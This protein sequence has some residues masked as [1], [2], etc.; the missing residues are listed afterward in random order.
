MSDT[1]KY[2][3][4]ELAEVLNV[5]RTTVTDWLVRY[6][7]Y[8]DY[9]I[10]GKRKVY[11]DMSVGVLKEISELRN[12]GLSSY[13]IEEELS[14]RHP[15]HGE[16]AD[17]NQ[18]MEEGLEPEESDSTSLVL[19]K[20]M[21]EMGETIKNTLIEVNRRM[22]ELEKM[23][24]ANASKANIWFAVVVILMFALISV[25]AFFYLKI[26][27]SYTANQT[28][29]LENRAYLTELKKAQEQMDE[30][31]NVIQK[32]ETEILK[33]ESGLEKQAK[34]MKDSEAARTAEMTEQK[35][36]W[37]EEKLKLLKDLDNAKQDKEK[38][39]QVQEA[40]KKQE[41][42]QNEQIKKIEEKPALPVEIKEEPK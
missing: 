27:T 34:E 25:G 28:L 17:R 42:A 22:E 15:V 29:L 13:D 19:R 30:N 2:T 6:S 21:T 12:K 5:P 9:K 40:V 18:P 24:E 31:R 11:T 20:S 14:K 23:N 36:K 39:S 7:P 35:N 8:I 4:I 3:V 16:V 32:K 41:E 26:E 33:L 10:Q 1:K 38:L 37:A